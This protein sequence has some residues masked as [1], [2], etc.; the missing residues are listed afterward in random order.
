MRDNRPMENPTTAKWDV[1]LKHAEYTKILKGF[2]P[3]DMDDKWLIH[4]D[5][6]D[7]QGNTTVRFFRSWTGYEQ[8]ALDIVAGSPSETDADIWA[9]IVSITW[10]KRNEPGTFLSTEEEAKEVAVALYT[11]FILRRQEIDD[12]APTMVPGR[13]R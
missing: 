13:P 11:N 10:D 3:R 5:V 1:P 2:Q 9:K 12:G 6:P 8:I 4:A 7:T